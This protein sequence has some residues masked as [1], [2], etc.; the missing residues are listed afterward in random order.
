MN[1]RNGQKSFPYR[2]AHLWNDLK[3]RDKIAPSLF[4]FK[5]AIKEYKIKKWIKKLVIALM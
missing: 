4:A 2:G 1:T 5:R 3:P